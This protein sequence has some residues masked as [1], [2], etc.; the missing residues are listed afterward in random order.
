MLQR[1][2]SKQVPKFFIFSFLFSITFVSN[3]TA[4]VSLVTSLPDIKYIAEQ[5]AGDR[6]EIS[7]MI[8]GTDDPH[9]VMTR[10]DFLVKLSEADVLC[11][12]GLDLE[13]GWIPYLQQQSRNIKIQKGQPGYCDT[14]FGVKILGEPTVMMD[15]SMGDMHIY[16]NPHYSNDPINAI[17]MAQNIKNALTRVDPLNG[18]YYE[19]NF[20]SFKKRLIQLTKEEMKKMEPY[21]GLKVAVFHDQFV[22]LASRFKFNANLTIEERPG[23]PPSVRYMDQVIS[24]MTAEKIKIILIGPYHNPKYAEYVSSKVPG[25]VVVTLPVSVGGS[26]EAVTYEDTLR[27]MLQKIRDASDKTK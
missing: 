11:V 14:S 17:Q 20:N 22:Y 12:I 3:L 6:V 7:G 8:R 27:I 23:V 9:F 19:G 21:F 15:R 16:G 25:S 2:F 4:K 5:V 1:M 10:P 26:P 24:Y 18:E 13:I